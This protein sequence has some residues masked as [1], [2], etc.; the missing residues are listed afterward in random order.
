MLLHYFHLPAARCQNITYQ[1]TNGFFPYIFCTD[2][3]TWCNKVNFERNTRNKVICW[4][5]GNKNNLITTIKNGGL[6]N[7]KAYFYY[8]SFTLS[9]Y[10]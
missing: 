3:I 4:L 9:G 8:F 2:L 1:Y 10:Q 6:K 7:E 5:R